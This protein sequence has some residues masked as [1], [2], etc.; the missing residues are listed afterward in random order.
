MQT[1][2]IEQTKNNESALMANEL[3]Y[4]GPFSHQ[5]SDSFIS[6]G[7]IFLQGFFE[8]ESI[9]KVKGIFSCFVELAQNMADYNE[10][11]FAE[12]LP[13]NF[14]SM[15]VFDNTVSITTR[16]IINGDDKQGIEDRLVNLFSQNSDELDDSHKDAIING[17]SLGLIMIKRLEE[18]TF[19]YSFQQN[20]ENNYWLNLE[21]KIEYGATAH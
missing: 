11:H 21:L 16:N 9:K 20:E 6:M 10:L 2:K 3:K 8:G 1:Q 13:L 4:C 5:F 17:K 18:S 14:I 15:E 12:R 19:N 7:N